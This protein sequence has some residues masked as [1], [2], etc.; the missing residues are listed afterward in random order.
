MNY[1]QLLANAPDHMTP[2][3][4]EYLKENNVVMVDEDFWLIIENAKYHSKDK[5][6]YTAFWKK[7]GTPDDQEIQNL[8]SVYYDFDLLIKARKR[9]SVKRFHVHLIQYK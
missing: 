4:L 7:E 8:H 5:P 6:W 2:E 1:E 3:F 9:R